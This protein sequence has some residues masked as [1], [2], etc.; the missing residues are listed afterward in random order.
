MVGLYMW[1]KR[2]KYHPLR[3]SSRESH[4]SRQS[5]RSASPQQNNEEDTDDIDQ[6]IDD[7]NSRI[8]LRNNPLTYFPEDTSL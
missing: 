6:L 3:P 4:H 7:G 5:S 2:K 1:Y 8:K